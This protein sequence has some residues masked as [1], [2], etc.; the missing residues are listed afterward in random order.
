MLV[1]G[2]Q[3]DPVRFALTREK[4][5]DGDDRFIFDATESDDQAPGPIN[6]LMNPGVP[7]MALGL[8]YLGGD[9]AQVCKAGGPNAID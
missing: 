2:P 7:G 6:Y 5:E 9:P 1:T 3:A 4:G 8:Y